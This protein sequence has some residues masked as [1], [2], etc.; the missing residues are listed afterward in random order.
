M[1]NCRLKSNVVLYDAL[2]GFREGRGVGTATLEANLVQQLAGLTHKP[3]FRVLLNVRRAYDSLYRGK[4]LE[5]LRGY[6]LGPNIS[7]LLDNYWKR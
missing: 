4:C 2:C 6:W 1:V 3:L 7:R 5:L